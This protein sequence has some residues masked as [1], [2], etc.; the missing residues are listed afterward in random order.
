MKAPV[1]SPV[2]GTFDIYVKTLTGIT[3]TIKTHS[4]MTIEDLKDEVYRAGGDPP[5]M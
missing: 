3:H 2:S 1:V 5:D 4:E